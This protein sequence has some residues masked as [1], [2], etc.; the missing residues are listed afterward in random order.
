L[1]TI[2]KIEFTNEDG[3]GNFKNGGQ[4]ASLSDSEDFGTYG[5]TETVCHII[6]TDA[7]GQDKR[8]DEGDD[9]DP[10]KFA[11]VWDVGVSDVGYHFGHCLQNHVGN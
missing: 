4:N 7:K 2:L 3:S 8:N 6:G 10:K 11:G 1:I 9:D 5:G